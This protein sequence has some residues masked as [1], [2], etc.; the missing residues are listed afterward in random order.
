MSA[1]PAQ[2]VSEQMLID[3]VWTDREQRI[4][5]FNP[6]DLQEEVG[7]M[8]CGSAA[9]VDR[10]VQ[11]AHRRF[12]SWASFSMKERAELL[13]Q[14]A[15]TLVANLDL[16]ATLL[17]RESGKPLFEA[18]NEIRAASAVL[19]YYASVADTF[20]E[21]QPHPSPNG[22]VLL[23]REPMGV[24]SVIVP[25]NAPVLLTLMSVAP[26]LL[27]GNTVVLKPSREAPLTL[28]DVI[29]S[30]SA[31]LPP[32]VLNL[33][34]DSQHG[35]EVGESLVTHPL[36]RRVMFTG[37]TETG[38]VVA[39]KAAASLKRVA[40]ELGGNDPAIVLS[41]ADLDGDVIP[42]IAAG[43]Y[44]STGQ[45]CYGVKRVYVH[46][47]LYR[48]FVERFSV[49]SDR[50]IVGNGLHPS[51]SMGP[52]INRGQLARVTDMV[53]EADARG[54]A[55][56]RL[57]RELDPS[58][59]GKGCFHMPTVISDVDST[60]QIV[61]CEQFGP[62]IPIMPFSSEDE[63][64]ALANN[65]E[66]GLASSIWT[67]DEDHGIALARRIEAGTTFINVHRAGAS[68][69]DMPFGGVKQSGVGRGHGV[70]ALEEQF[71]LHTISTRRPATGIPVPDITEANERH[72]QSS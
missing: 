37:S 25:W 18:R 44:A 48:D 39:A 54:A 34:P 4:P 12:P 61:T 41:D 58:S 46:E 40:L 8:P 50:L 71:E 52:L 26:A 42:E 22:R 2:P 67:R 66:Y 6:A 14:A 21:V 10:A 13:R 28:T 72:D 51:T 29:R 69:I 19:D 24:A 64:V 68:G 59:W 17:V 38:R 65:S 9:D 62:A 31:H 15:S 3:G 27:A 23:A 56:R 33:V 36:V 16:R 57:G 45:L 53:A 60:F 5:V 35:H 7:S 55:V 47:T 49:E 11:A 43:A 63:A 30:I 32:G 20:E 70:I 1:S